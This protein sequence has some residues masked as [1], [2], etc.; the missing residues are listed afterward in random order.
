ML[1]EDNSTQVSK[2]LGTAKEIM[3][4]VIGDDLLSTAKLFEPI[5]LRA[6]QEITNQIDALISDS[7]IANS[8]MDPTPIRIL[9][10]IRKI[11]VTR[12]LHY[13]SSLFGYQLNIKLC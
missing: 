13:M 9:T 8:V 6:T 1:Y 4:L 11:V 10:Q 5:A 12:I 3:A 2:G 7:N